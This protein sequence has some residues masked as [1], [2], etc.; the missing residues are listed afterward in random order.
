MIGDNEK[1]VLGG[2]KAET[3]PYSRQHQLRTG[4][5]G[6]FGKNINSLMIGQRKEWTD[7]KTVRRMD[8]QMDGQTD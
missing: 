6:V 1:I 2:T 8:R 5:K 7:E 4:G 3:R